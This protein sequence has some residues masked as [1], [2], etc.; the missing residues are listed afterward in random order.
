MHSLSVLG[1][2]LANIIED[3][4]LPIVMNA[5]WVLCADIVPPA[6]ACTAFDCICFIISQNN[7]D[8]C[9]NFDLGGVDRVET[10]GTDGHIKVSG[11]Y[12]MSVLCA[13]IVSPAKACTAFE[14][15]HFVNS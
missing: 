13:D 1:Q 14:C 7:I 12:P 10:L 9:S 3:Y 6:K 4:L 15:I 8:F 2:H 5:M 11:F